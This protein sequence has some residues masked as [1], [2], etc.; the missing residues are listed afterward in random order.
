MTMAMLAFL[1]S[2]ADRG[3]QQAPVASATRASP[4]LPPLFPI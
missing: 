3:W 1:K 2:E 4:A